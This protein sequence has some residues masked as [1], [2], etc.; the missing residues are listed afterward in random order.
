[1]GRQKSDQRQLF[2][3]FN[4]EARIPAHHLLRRINL[5]LAGYGLTFARSWASLQ[6]DWS[7]FD[8]PRTD[9]PDADRRLLLRHSF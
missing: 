1:M 3:L 8:R 4:L 6:R 9:D 5:S 7:A 2:Y